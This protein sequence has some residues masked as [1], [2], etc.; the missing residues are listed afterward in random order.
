MQSLNEIHKSLI[1]TMT[2]GDVD[3]YLADTFDASKMSSNLED[4]Q[5]LSTV[6]EEVLNKFVT[7]MS[8][9]NAADKQGA[10][11]KLGTFSDTTEKLKA[12]EEAV[13]QAVKLRDQ[14]KADKKAILAKLSDKA[15][16]VIRGAHIAIDVKKAELKR[17]AFED[18]QQSL[19]SPP[20]VNVDISAAGIVGAIGDFIS[21]VGGG[22]SS[23]KSKKPNTNNA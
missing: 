7:E 13:T 9:Q 14:L 18:Y 3:A 19:D 11:K 21:A 20:G 6:S 4:N 2:M 22:S 16:K 12:A 1:T 5:V 10:S 23:K 15:V 8:S 17:K